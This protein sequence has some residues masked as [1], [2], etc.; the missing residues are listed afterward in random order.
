MFSCEFCEISKNTFFTEHL[1]TAASAS[2]YYVLI[3]PRIVKKQ[4]KVQLLV[5]SN[6]YDEVIDFEPSEF[7]KDANFLIS[8]EIETFQKQPFT[9]VLQNSCSSKSTICTGNTC[10]FIKERLQHRKLCLN[11]AKF[12]R[13]A[14]FYRTL[15]VAGSDVFS[16]NKKIIQKKIYTGYIKIICIQD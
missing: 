8:L 1:R 2:A 13:T 16:S 15:Q 5:C 9:D 6:V 14:F 7:I 11:I 10:G 12:L 3:L 4:S